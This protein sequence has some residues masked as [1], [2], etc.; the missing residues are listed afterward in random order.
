MKRSIVFAA[1]A[2]AAPL[3]AQIQPV[4]PSPSRTAQGDVAVTI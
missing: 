4:L 1:A 3:A 2:I